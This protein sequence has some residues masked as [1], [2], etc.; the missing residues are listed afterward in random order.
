MTKT[1]WATL[2]LIVTAISAQAQT[3]SAQDL[4]RRTIERRAVEA[5]IWGM[6]L[7]NTDAMR[8]AYFRDVGAKYNDIC[9]F[10][11]PQDWKFQV[12]TPNASTNYIYFNYNLKDGPVV[13]EMPAAVNA[14]L[15]GSMV[16]AWDEPMTDIGPAGEDQGKGGKY[17]LLPPDFKG[18]T[19]AG[20]FPIRYPTYNGYAL[21]RA[22]RNGTT[23]AD[24]AAALALVKKLRVYPFAQAATPQNNA[25]STFTARRSMA[26]P[27]STSVSL[28]TSTAWFRKSRCYRA[29]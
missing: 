3:F 25:S 23:D 6:P 28:R 1:V 10:S 22:I 13:V 11:K 8:Q 16:D 29:T 17:L 20:F 12:T 18:D 26:S 9:Y 4:A 2:A 15:L 24:T 27:T 21:Y 14:G 5:A 7:V 19:P